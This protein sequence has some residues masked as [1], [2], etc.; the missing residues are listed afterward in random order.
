MPVIQTQEAQEMKTAV[1][2]VLLTASPAFVTSYAAP[3][4]QDVYSR[5]RAF[6]LDV[7]PET[8]IHSLYD[9]RDRSTPLWTFSRGIWYGPILVS[10][11][12][13]VVAIVAWEHVQVDDIA[14]VKAVEFWNRSGEFRSYPLTELC[15]NPPK[16]QDVGIGPIGGFWR[17][18]HAD[19]EDAGDGFRLMT[20]RCAEYVFRYS[21]GEL[22][23]RRWYWWKDRVLRTQLAVGAGLVAILFG[24]WSQSGR[25]IRSR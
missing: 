17:T 4:R 11:D 7:N 3:E 15:P 6:V 13:A 22:T 8:D 2:V 24:L 12:G 14:D 9:V 25:R 16:T 20:T 19:H 21:D 10:D 5:N 23:L 18:W 1:L